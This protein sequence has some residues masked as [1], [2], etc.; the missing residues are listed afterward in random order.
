MTKN[1]Y[2][3]YSESDVEVIKRIAFLRT[4]DISI[5]DIRNIMS[6]QVS[7]TEMLEKQVTTIQAQIEGL[8][9]A[10]TM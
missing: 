7:L 8:N 1:G 3:D 5:E 2:R 6:D 10:R 9:Q 4:L